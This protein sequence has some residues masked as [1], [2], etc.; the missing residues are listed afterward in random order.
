MNGT[1]VKVY[2]RA[3]DGNT[4]VAEHFRV[5][6]FACGDGS[7][8]VFIAPLLVEVLETIRIYFNAPVTV[9][10]GYRTEARNKAVGGSAYSQH[11]YGLAADICVSG[12]APEKVASYA[13]TLLED[14]GGIGLY[15][16]FVHIDVRTEKARWNG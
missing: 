1:T 12:V 3:K 15:P 4:K 14:S 16:T 8:A 10:S 11:K 2:S 9:S 7:D 6:E 5:R 13:E